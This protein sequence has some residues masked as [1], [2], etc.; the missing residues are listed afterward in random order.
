M[1]KHLLAL[2]VESKDQ[3]VQ[4]KAFG[5]L[6]QAC[7]STGDSEHALSCHTEELKLLRAL[8]DRVRCCRCG[9]SSSSCVLVFFRRLA[10]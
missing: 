4:A 6:A 1:F 10:G 8:G 5:G 2:G 7:R 3:A 9:A